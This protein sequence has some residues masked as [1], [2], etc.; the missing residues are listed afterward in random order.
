MLLEVCS[1]LENFA[2]LMKLFA[3]HESMVRL[4][5]NVLDRIE[6]FYWSKQYDKY[7]VDNQG[8]WF[9]FVVPEELVDDIIASAKE[10]PTYHK[11]TVRPA[12]ENEL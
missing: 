3:L 10:L 2:K 11:F 12:R 6:G 9:D 4:N 1:N 5:I 8:N 7:C